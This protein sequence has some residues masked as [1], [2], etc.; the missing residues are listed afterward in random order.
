[1]NILI[2]LN[3]FSYFIYFSKLSQQNRYFYLSGRRKFTRNSDIS[4]QYINERSLKENNHLIPKGD[5]ENYYKIFLLYNQSSWKQVR[6]AA[7]YVENY[8]E[9]FI[10]NKKINFVISGG[11]TGIERCALTIARTM[12]IPA[13]CVWEGY[14]RPDTISVDP[15]GM[16]AESMF[17]AGLKHLKFSQI[18][19][20]CNLINSYL[21]TLKTKQIIQS[22]YKIQNGKFNLL[23][24]LRNRWQDREDFER[25][26]LPYY[27][28]F[29]ARLVYYCHQYKDLN[30]LREPFIFFPLQT[31]T[32]SNIFLNGSLFPYDKYIDLVVK[33]FHAVMRKIK[34]KLVIKEHPFDVFRK[35][36]P[37]EENKGTIW[38]RP[39]ESCI[40]ILN[41]E[42]CIG[43]IVVNSTTG[44]ESMLLRKPVLV[45]GKSIYA[46][47]DLTL[48][49][50]DMSVDH[51]SNKLIEIRSTVLNDDYV[52]KFASYLYETTQFPGNLNL[53]PI[54]REVEL[55]ENT[56]IN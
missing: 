2:I 34:C 29:T 44:L 42:N 54:S 10:C 45:L 8:L 24:Q 5:W 32:D 48:I 6:S 4:T 39:E 7:A 33:A 17:F 23:Y 13:L 55:F 12:K 47:S 56:F 18:Y 38:I 19:N 26:R 22:L 20:S 43:T 40:N 37:K 16:N 51:I 28:Q 36:Y 49:A 31:H 46:H 9:D 53:I 50:K 3:H 41:N 15:R 52:K 1:M 35:Y 14:F 21:E 30:D 25:I 11:S 27:S